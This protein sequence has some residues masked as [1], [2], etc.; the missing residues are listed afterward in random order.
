MIVDDIIAARAGLDRLAPNDIVT[1]PVD[2]VYLQDGNSPTI[3][4][5]FKS[6]G[7]SR[8][9]DP[10][11]IG[12][13][14]DHSVIWPNKD[15]S[16]RI[17][18]A[19]SFA[20]QFGLRVFR[21]G[22]GISHVVA[23]EEG[24]FAPGTVTLGTDSHT[25]TG[26]ALDCLALGMGASDVVAAML[27][28]KTWL[29]VPETVVIETRGTPGQATSAKDVILYALATF[30]QDHFLYRSI[31]WRGAW[32]RRLSLDARATMASMAVEMGAKCVFLEGSPHAA[33]IARLKPMGVPP[34]E[35]LQLDIEALQP[36]IARP[37]LPQSSG[38][39]SEMAG[40]AI[41]YV[42]VGSCTNSRLEDL[43]DVARVLE[44]RT[45]APGV[46][47]LVTPGSRRVFQMASEAG[48]VRTIMEAGAVVTP[49][50]CGACLGTQGSIPA[51][52][53]KIVSTMNRNF[54]GRM[55]NPDSEIYLASPH[56]AALCA[57]LG[58]VP[59]PHEVVAP[60]P[61]PRPVEGRKE[62]VA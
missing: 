46:H 34:V 17:R 41:N 7:F 33:D 55:G 56:V 39:V 57:V 21:G 47:C 26:G 11:R 43:A 24:W 53:D 15:I 37:H 49:P 51:D 23:M 42:F 38:P 1:V 29:R 22:E 59:Y 9:F 16:N 25:C 3:A 44:G 61:A 12:I 35:V 52:G 32:I 58:R 45:V 19:M 36:Y 5:I 50:G 14:F 28:G 54:K 4:K 10:E 27:T 18:E 48:Y 60:A 2:R 31:E 13:F 6:E 20:E 62:A 40:T 30:G 8:V